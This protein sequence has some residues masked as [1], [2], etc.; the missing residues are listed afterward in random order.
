MAIAQVQL[1]LRRHSFYSVI[2]RH[3]IRFDHHLPVCRL[4]RHLVLLLGY[5]RPDAIN[6][7]A[8]N[9]WR[10]VACAFAELITRHDASVHDPI[11]VDHVQGVSTVRCLCGVVRPNVSGKCNAPIV[12]EMLA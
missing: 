5:E 10:G 11:A 9:R 8:M 6:K 1:E 7:V 12:N 4:N 3:C 2:V